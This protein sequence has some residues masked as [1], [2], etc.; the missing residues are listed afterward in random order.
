MT[1]VL[2]RVDNRLVHGQ[3]VEAWVPRLGIQGIVV[4]DGELAVDPFQI[5]VF[6]ALDR[7]NL[8]VRVCGP[9]EAAALMEREWRDKRILLLFAGLP[10]AVDSRRRGVR[11]DTLNLGNIH[12]RPGSRTLT[13]SVYLTEED[14]ACLRALLAE[15]VVL[16]ARAVPAD[17]SPD[18]VSFLRGAA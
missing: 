8:P 14:G 13:P 16:E 4:V 5:L 15:G 10:Q 17:R 3:V 9:E 2:A 1:V 12:P 7:D 11:F 18:V 6:Q